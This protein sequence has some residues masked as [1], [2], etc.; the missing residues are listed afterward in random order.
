MT[1]DLSSCYILNCWREAT[2]IQVSRE[3][4][5]FCLISARDSATSGYVGRVCLLGYK[6]AEYLLVLHTNIFT[7]ATQM[8]NATSFI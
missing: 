6:S 4:I 3:S 1:P 8:R 7:S 5:C 2:Q